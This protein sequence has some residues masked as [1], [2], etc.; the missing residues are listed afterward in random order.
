MKFA[1]GLF[2]VA[3]AGVLLLAF[4]DASAIICPDGCGGGGSGP[5]ETLAI[6]PDPATSAQQILFSATVGDSCVYQPNVPCISGTVSFWVTPTSPAGSP[7]VACY[8]NLTSGNAITSYTSCHATLAM[9]VYS[10][11][12]T[13]NGN[14]NYPAGSSNPASMTVLSPTDLIFANGFQ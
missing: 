14:A 3:L 12:A 9:G 4:Q 2:R 11:K 10:V 6:T 5:G 7:Y 8:G 13:Y 1:T